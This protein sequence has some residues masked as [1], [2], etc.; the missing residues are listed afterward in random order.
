[1]ENIMLEGYVYDKSLRK[2]SR[3]VMLKDPAALKALSNDV[4]VEILRILS[5][6]PMSV[7]ELAKELNLSIQA[8]SYHVKVLRRYGL[9]DVASTQEIRGMLKKRYIAKAKAYAILLDEMDDV[10]T[11]PET[12]PEIPEIFKPFIN[13]D[14]EFDGYIVIGSPEPHGRFGNRAR[15][16]VYAVWLALYLGSLCKVSPFAVVY[17]TRASGDVVSSNLIIVGGPTCNVVAE[18]INESSP[19]YIDT[20]RDNQIISKLSGRVYTE[21]ENGLIA[22]FRNPFN[23][24]KFVLWIA[25]RGLK[26]TEAAM[27]ALVRYTSEVSS[28]NKS[29]PD[30]IAHVVLGVDENSDGMIDNVQILE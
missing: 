27:L 9:I 25:G 28:P 16:H 4:R 20:S 8:V 6:K 15:D 18:A 13:S 29:R 2:F 11:K 5:K 30:V 23:S 21:R 22:L 12:P 14:G 7:S 1:M 19:I 17:D 24:K 10:T 26:G 3:C